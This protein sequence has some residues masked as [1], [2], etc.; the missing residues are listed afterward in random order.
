[1]SLPAVSK[2]LGHASIRSTERYLH[3]L[4]E[5]LQREYRDASPVSA[6]LRT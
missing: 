1:M 5:D 3:L 6:V 4:T 2:Q